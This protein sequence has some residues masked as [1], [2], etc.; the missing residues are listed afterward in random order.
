MR[1]LRGGGM[2]INRQTRKTKQ[3]KKAPNK[4][5][6]TPQKTKLQNSNVFFC[7][8]LAESLIFETNFGCFFLLLVDA[9]APTPRTKSLWC[10][11]GKG[12]C[13]RRFCCGSASIWALEMCDW[14]G[15]ARTVLCLGIRSCSWGWRIPCGTCVS[16]CS[17]ARSTSQ[18]CCSFPNCL[19][20]TWALWAASGKAPVWENWAFPHIHPMRKLSFPTYSSNLTAHMVS[21]L[22]APNMPV[23][24]HKI[25]H[26]N[27]HT[28]RYVPA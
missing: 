6:T 8:L 14:P 4:Q 18:S 11:D 25:Q 5:K 15:D 27:I 24:A 20:S 7:R 10:M 16:L 9:V 22:F 23:C 1:Q 28:Y 13:I 26:P 2:S 21:E 3:P 19:F 12:I 17:K